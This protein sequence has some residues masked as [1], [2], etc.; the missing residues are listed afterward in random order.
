MIIAWAMTVLS[1]GNVLLVPIGEAT[2]SPLSASPGVFCTIALMGSIGA[3][4]S[5]LAIFVVYDAGPFWFRLVCH[6]ALATFAL[7]A[8]CLGY[9][10]AFANSW[11]WAIDG[12]FF[13]AAVC[14]LPF[15]AIACQMPHWLMR[16]YFHWRIHRSDVNAAA[17]QARPLAISDFL[18]ATVVVA[19]TI[20]AL[21]IGQPFSGES[22]L[23][24]IGWSIG[25]GVAT[26][27]TAAI[28]LPTMWLVLCIE[29][30]RLA[31]LCV[32]ILTIAITILVSLGLIYLAPGGPSDALKAF[33]AS[34][35][36]FGFVTALAG[37][38]AI[39]RWNGVR[40]VTSRTLP[41]SR[42]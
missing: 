3:Q 14:G 31:T 13:F 8:W 6:W 38:L 28:V 18:V 35:L 22:E 34:S 37:T 30:W 23:F 25:A 12:E 11:R 41:A 15:L 20:T 17:C 40:L 36:V 19:L 9:T 4:A 39:I 26:G 1:L 32:A 5:L 24:W 16:T 7:M 42:Q 21:R 10:A 2:G 33:M 29:D 27:I